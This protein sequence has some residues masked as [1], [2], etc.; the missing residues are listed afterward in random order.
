MCS[1]YLVFI[2]NV[3]IEFK[4]IR[5][6]ESVDHFLRELSEE[7]ISDLQYFFD[8]RIKFSRCCRVFPF[9]ICFSKREMFLLLFE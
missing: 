7:C 9:F 3:F 1:P 6:H 8:I 2:E 5:L 4:I